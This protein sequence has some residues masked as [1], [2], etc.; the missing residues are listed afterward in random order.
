MVENTMSELLGQED[1]GGCFPV[2]RHAMA[3]EKKGIDPVR[4]LET[5]LFVIDLQNKGVDFC[6]VLEP[7]LKKRSE[8]AT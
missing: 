3:L 7:I 5:V 6:Q 4:L 1:H 2:L 8:A